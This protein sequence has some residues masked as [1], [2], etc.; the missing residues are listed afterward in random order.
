MSSSP[1]LLVP[2]TEAPRQQ[3][4]QVE[5]LDDTMMM[6]PSEH[7]GGG[8]GALLGVTLGAGMWAGILMLAG[9]IK[10]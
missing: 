5:E 2:G 8:K 1:L 9:V 3:D 10:F 6:D 4:S 7:R